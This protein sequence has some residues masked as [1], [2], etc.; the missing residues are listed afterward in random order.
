MRRLATV[1]AREN[2]PTT[3]DVTTQPISISASFTKV[4][5]MA[6][7]QYGGWNYYTLQ[8]GTILTLIS[9]G[10]CNLQCRMWL[11]NHDS[12]PEECYVMRLEKTLTEIKTS[13]YRL[14]LYDNIIIIIISSTHRFVSS[15]FCLKIQNA[16]CVLQ[17]QRNG[18]QRQPVLELVRDGL[19]EE[20]NA[21]S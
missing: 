19:A 3:N 18:P 7:F 6:D 5:N 21:S 13:P 17:S 16:V 20:C 12:K 14:T 15:H 8:C 11:W 4:N 10:D 9:P 1:H 2:Q